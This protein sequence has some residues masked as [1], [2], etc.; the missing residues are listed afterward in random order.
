MGGRDARTELWRCWSRGLA[1]PNRVDG[2]PMYGLANGGDQA[3]IRPAATW[4]SP[5]SGWPPVAPAVCREGGGGAAEGRSRVGIGS[6][7]TTGA[8]GASPHAAA[9]LDLE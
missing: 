1:P 4:R 9:P 6:G 8:G 5:L 3:L 7:P 2:N